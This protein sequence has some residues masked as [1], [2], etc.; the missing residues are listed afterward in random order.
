MRRTG[1]RCTARGTP[2]RNLSTRF[3]E[4]R[5]QGKRHRSSRHPH[6]F[7][8]K[9]FAQYVKLYVSCEGEAYDWRS[10][11]HGF[12]RLGWRTERR[13]RLHLADELINDIVRTAAVPESQLIRLRRDP[14]HD[15]LLG[16]IE[17]R[18]RP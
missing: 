11:L 3:Q 5:L 16:L 6:G 8:F 7:S 14:T 18:E 15:E 2:L 9:G 12:P 17:A 1:G 13:Q 10:D 4:Y